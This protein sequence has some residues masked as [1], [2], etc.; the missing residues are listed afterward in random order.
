MFQPPAENEVL[1]DLQ[2]SW[3]VTRTAEVMKRSKMAE[4]AS[5]WGGSSSPW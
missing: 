3:E 1:L 2:R 5:V 4:P